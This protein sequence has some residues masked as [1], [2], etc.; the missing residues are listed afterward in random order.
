MFCH[1][2]LVS[3]TTDDS[4]MT[5]AE[6]CDAMAPFGQNYV[7]KIKFC[8]A[9]LKLHWTLISFNIKIS[10]VVKFSYFVGL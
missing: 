9:I 10:F 4:V 3:Q 1:S 8:V 2:T 5:V 7:I 6:L